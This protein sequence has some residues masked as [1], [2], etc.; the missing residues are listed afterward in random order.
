[1][2]PRIIPVL[3]YLL[4]LHLPLLSGQTAVRRTSFTD[5]RDSLAGVADT[6]ALRTAFRRS[7]DSDAVR[8]GAIALRLGELGADSDYS[9][10]VDRF[11]QAVQHQ[12][13][14]DAW[15]GLGLAY[16]GRSRHEMQDRL[17]L[18]SRVGLGALERAA[19]SH[20]R[21]LGADPHFVPAALAL[22]DIELSLLDTTRLK[23][24]RRVLRVAGGGP[25]RPPPGGGPPGPPPAPPGRAPFSCA[26]HGRLP[27]PGVV[28]GPIASERAGGP[29][30]RQG[31]AV[32]RGPQA[33]VGAGGR[34][35]RRPR[36][37]GGR[38]APPAR[39]APPP[40]ARATTTT[41]TR[42]FIP[43]L[44]SSQPTIS[45]SSHLGTTKS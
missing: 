23:R 18:G 1:M 41:A 43:S 31:G 2:G 27:S 15:Y 11:R 4:G 36:G 20:A 32:K 13:S 10:A 38:P 12:P 26:R 28:A 33:P 3:L 8:G 19:H 14:P 45:R 44:R 17:R 16:S 25:A 40:P 42:A 29:A 7:P 34:G 6:I 35:R 21:A 30:V 24:A 5:L 9:L 39:P 37:G 22:A